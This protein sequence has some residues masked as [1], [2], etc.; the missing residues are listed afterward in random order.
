MVVKPEITRVENVVAVLVAVHFSI[1]CTQV[2]DR[3]QDEL[4]EITLSAV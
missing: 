1:G 3:K 2:H 4:T